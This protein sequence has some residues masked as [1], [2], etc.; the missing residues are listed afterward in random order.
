ME[1]L[2]DRFYE[3]MEFSMKQKFNRYIVK[4]SQVK[5]SFYVLIRKPRGKILGD[6]LR[7]MIENVKYLAEKIYRNFARHSS[8]FRYKCFPYFKL[9][10]CYNN[11]RYHF[12]VVRKNYQIEMI[13][14]LK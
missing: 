5:G 14:Y 8:D 11:Y 6:D 9:V 2:L 12:L 1:D 4:L 7:F 3:T 13:S 10:R